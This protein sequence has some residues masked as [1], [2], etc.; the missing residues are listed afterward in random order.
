MTLC[1]VF[2]GHSDAVSMIMMCARNERAKKE[3]GEAELRNDAGWEGVRPV[4]SVHPPGG[5]SGLEP[6][7]HNPDDN[8]SYAELSGYAGDL[9]HKARLAPG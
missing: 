7:F 2:S 4:H 3:R 6:R 8:D 5:C 1:H 9:S